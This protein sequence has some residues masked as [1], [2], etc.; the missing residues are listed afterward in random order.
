MPG[1]DPIRPRGSAWKLVVALL[2]VVLAVLAG[3]AQVVHMHA[4][5]T[6]THADC[7]LCAAAH[8][9]VQAAVQVQ[10]VAPPVRL[11]QAVE[12]RL[13]PRPARLDLGF[14][15]FDRPPPVA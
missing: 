4:D 13:Q 11:V 15:L 2:C 6:D 9:G 1:L 8:V 7:S 14:A 3:T 5:G 10:A 12:F